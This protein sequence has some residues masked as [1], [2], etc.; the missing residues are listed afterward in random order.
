LGVC[1]AVL[2]YYACTVAVVELVAII[3]HALGFLAV[4]LG[5]GWAVLAQQSIREEYLQGTITHTSEFTRHRIRRALPTSSI[6]PCMSISTDTPIN[7]CPDLV[8]TTSSNTYTCQF[9]KSKLTHT[10]ITPI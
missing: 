10:N 1:R 6:N 5:V 7:I 3:A 4:G 9:N 2:D 8:D